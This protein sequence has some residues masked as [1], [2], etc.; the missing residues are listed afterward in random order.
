MNDFRVIKIKHEMGLGEWKLHLRKTLRMF[1]IKWP[2][3]SWGNRKYDG[4]YI[5]KECVE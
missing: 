1:N 5:F 3:R 2:S 4:N